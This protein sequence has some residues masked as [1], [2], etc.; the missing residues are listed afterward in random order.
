MPRFF[1]GAF[2]GSRHRL[3]ADPLC[4]ISTLFSQPHCQQGRVI[5]DR[6]DRETDGDRE[7]VNTVGL[8]A[9]GHRVPP[10][11]VHLTLNG[12]TFPLFLTASF[13]FYS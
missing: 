3:S 9:Q 10:A 7:N 4:S 1:D 2:V 5:A 8:R 13:K 12:F 11:C 6:E